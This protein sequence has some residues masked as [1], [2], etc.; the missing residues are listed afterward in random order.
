MAACC[1]AVKQAATLLHAPAR[2]CQ[3]V[4]SIP[5]ETRTRRQRTYFLLG[6]RAVLT[7]FDKI[8]TLRRTMLYTEE[9]LD[10]V[11]IEVDLGPPF[12]CLWDSRDQETI[13]TSNKRLDVHQRACRRFGY[14][15]RYL[16]IRLNIAQTA[17]SA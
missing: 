6:E 8:D 4:S 1:H 17:A 9:L 13:G 16:D 3:S 11:A 7:A 10:H 5:V 15:W 12:T 14:G 2:S